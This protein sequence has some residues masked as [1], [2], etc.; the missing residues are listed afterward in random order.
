MAKE[1]RKII[2]AGSLWM[3]VQYTT[4]RG[5]NQSARREARSQ[6]STPARESLNAKMSWQK[7]MMVLATNF[8]SRDLVITLTYR[9]ENLPSTRERADKRLDNFIRSF[10]Q[11][12]RSRSADLKYVRT[13]EGYHSDGRLHHHLIANATGQDFDVIRVGAADHRNAADLVGSGY[14]KS[15]HTDSLRLGFVRLIMS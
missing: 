12:R 2:R 10:R 13:T 9:D 8:R 11:Y 1:R 15:W 14:K 3:A 4:I 5:E 7:L 6:I